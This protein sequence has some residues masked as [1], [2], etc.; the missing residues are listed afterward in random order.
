MLDEMSSL[1]L[2]TPC[3]SFES[4]TVLDL[5]RDGGTREDALFGEPGGHHIEKV[6]LLSL[7]WLF[8]LIFGHSFE[9][10]LDPVLDRGLIT[11][12]SMSHL[13]LFE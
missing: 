11:L 9:P 13:E 5:K 10:L 12:V 1:D 8:Q 2:L 3:H 6:T 7:L 4:P